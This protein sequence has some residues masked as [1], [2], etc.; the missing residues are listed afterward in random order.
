M[1]RGVEG[2]S[3]RGERDPQLV[4]SDWTPEGQEVIDGV[5]TFQM[6][7]VLAGNGYLTEI[8]RPE[9]ALDDAPVGQVFQRVLDPG[10]A[11][12]WH[13]HAET[14]DRLFCAVGRLL[15]VLYDARETSATH[16]ALLELRCGAERPALIVV[17][18]GVWHGVRNLGATTAVMVNV[19][20]RAYDYEHP[21]HFRVPV[22]SP[23]IPYRL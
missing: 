21:D 18:P 22:D 1:E 9:W 16:G 5:R 7:N 13:A 4:R 14:L 11:S 19:V 2:W 6:S 12:G 17:P 10:A 8:W 23:L 20:D 3:V 15:V